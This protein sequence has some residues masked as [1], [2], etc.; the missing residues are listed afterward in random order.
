M[1]DKKKI[2]V[3]SLQSLNAHSGAGMA[4]IGYHLSLELHKRDLLK[5]FIVSSKGKFT[6]TFPSHPVSFFSR[7]Y[8][9]VLNKLNKL[10]HFKNYK[11]RFIQELLFDWFLSLRIDNSISTIV[12]TNAYLYRTNKKAKKKGIQVYFIPANPEDNFIYNLVKEEQKKLNL[13]FTDA[14]TYKKRLEYYNKSL[15]YVDKII[16][17]FPSTY[18]QYSKSGTQDKLINIPGHLKSDFKPAKPLVKLNTDTYNVA[19][20]AYSVLLKGLQ[21]LMEAWKEIIQKGGTEN[22][23]LYIGGDIDS[24]IDEYIK[25]TFSNL[26]NV[27]YSG[28]ISNVPEF[29]KDKDLFV[30]PSLIDGGPVTALEAAH[31][32]IPVII[33]RNCGAREFFENGSGWVIPIQDAESIKGNIL[34][35]YRHREEARQMGIDAKQKLDNYKATFITDIADMLQNATA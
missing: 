15:K 23:H 17:T 11:F 16:A 31:Y 21:Y 7:Y 20:L 10:I 30:V 6:T 27:H 14:Y 4:R 1:P 25:T 28:H 13:S 8:L 24:S 29:L 32:G 12:S 9:F 5:Y 18:E 19:Y 33:T 26:K 2:L 3:A 34:W 22:M 35:A